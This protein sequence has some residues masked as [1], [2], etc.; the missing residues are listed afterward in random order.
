MG[1]FLQVLQVLANHN[2]AIKRVVLENAPKNLKLTSLKIQKDITFLDNVGLSWERGYQRGFQIGALG[3]GLQRGGRN[4]VTK[5]RRKSLGV[6]A[7]GS[8]HEMEESGQ[9]GPRRAGEERNP[10]MEGREGWERRM[11]SPG[12]REF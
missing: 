2:E 1:N 12:A 5:E 8:S 11:W 9:R 7:Q 10:A 6:A 4:L 3:E